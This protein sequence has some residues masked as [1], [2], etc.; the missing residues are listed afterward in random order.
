MAVRTHYE[1][2]TLRSGGD[3]LV[4]ATAGKGQEAVLVAHGLLASH[5]ELAPL[6]DGLAAHGFAV[7]APDLRGCGRSGGP[8]GHTSAPRAH[9]DIRVV[10]EWARDRG[11][12][13]KGAVG[14]SLGAA[15]LLYAAA[16]GT[17]LRR[18]VLAAP[19]ASIRAELKPGELL[20]YRA[21]HAVNRVWMRLGFP[22]LRVPYRVD[23]ED[24]VE[25]PV[26]RREAASLDFL[27]DTV[28][29]TNVPTLLAVDA[30][31]WARDV[32]VP[33]LFLASDTDRVVK[34][35]STRAVYD[36][37]AGPKEWR[38]IPGGHSV[39]FDAHRADAITA[40]A[41]WLRG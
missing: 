32:H 33:A 2:H 7:I 28:P 26:L 30:L 10:L 17:S 31:A 8:R 21:G 37:Y 18:L 9:E 40:T 11:L 25:D 13:L 35:A 20:A 19:P 34:T 5:L 39:Y 24:T 38:S 4:V 14:H 3:E 41:A 15:Y 1:A 6:L 36:A 27:Q 22:S 23:E 12:D 29:L 16:H